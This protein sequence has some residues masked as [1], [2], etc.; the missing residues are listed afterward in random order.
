MNPLSRLTSLACL[1]QPAPRSSGPAHT[2]ARLLCLI[3]RSAVDVAVL[4]YQLETETASLAAPRGPC[5]GPGQALRLASS[6][7]I[8]ASQGWRNAKHRAQWRSTLATY[9]FPVIGDV[10]VADIN[11]EY[12]CCGSWKPIWSN[13]TA[14]ASRV[15]GRIEKV[16]SSAKARNLRSGENPAAWRGHLDQLLPA[17]SKVQRVNHHPALSY[18]D[19]PAFMARLRLKEGVTARAL[20]FVILCASRTGEGLRAESTQFIWRSG[21]GPCRPRLRPARSIACPSR[22]VPYRSLRTWPLVAINEYVFAAPSAASPC[23]I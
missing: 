8:E 7:L 3:E 22:R 11:T 23:L 20:E 1:Q 17:R 21:C 5:R 15:R 9:A 19:L 14:T 16:L 6:F 18:R 10:A 2:V 12:L 13:K 4:D